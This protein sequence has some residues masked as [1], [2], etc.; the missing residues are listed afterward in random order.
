[1]SD[2]LRGE[3][4][5]F[6][7]NIGVSKV[8]VADATRGFEKAIR[9]CHPRDILRDCKSVIAFYCHIGM[10]YYHYL[11]YEGLTRRIGYIHRDWAG[12]KLVEFL[13]RRGYQATYPEGYIDE[14]RR[15]PIFSYKLAAYEAG[16]GVYGRS[17]IIVTPELGTKVLIGA[18][19]TDA[20]IEPD[21][22][23]TDFHPCENCQ[24]CIKTC[25][26][27]AISLDAEPPRG[28]DRE[29][30]IT[31]TD[32]LKEKMG[33]NQFLCGCCYK[34]C[35]VGARKRTSFKILVH[36]TLV[37]LEAIQRR[38]LVDEYKLGLGSEG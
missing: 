20:A 5:A 15:I 13:R 24:A 12:Y 17:S 10:Y 3:I 14:K 38:R 33:D 11:L 35:P 6:L 32:W 16:L 19:L 30:C 22:K 23:L 7:K 18:I 36:K 8:C 28:Y 4:E 29:A 25:P 27:N 37:G 21:G 34:S 26:I 9:G 2:R 1:M 31:F